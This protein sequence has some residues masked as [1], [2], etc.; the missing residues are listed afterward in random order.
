MSYFNR[1]LA[2]RKLIT[3][4]S[5]FK[6]GE[7]KVLLLSG[8]KGCGKTTLVLNFT[9]KVD[10]FY[11]SFA[12]LDD[13][14]ALRQFCKR[15]MEFLKTESI[16]SWPEA[17]S[18]LLRHRPI[19]IFDDIAAVASNKDFW[20]AFNNF[21]NNKGANRLFLYMIAEK[22][23]KLPL[24]QCPAVRL[25]MG[26][27]TISDLFKA[28]PGLSHED[29]LR[30][31]AVTGGIPELVNT[32]DA[33][34]S[35]EENLW[36]MLQPGS[37]F[38]RFCPEYLSSCFRCT[39]VYEHLLYAM[40][41]GHHRIGEIAAFTGFTSNK[42]DKYIKTM[43]ECGIVTCRQIPDKN[44]KVKTHYDLANGYFT[45]WYRYIYLN[46][47]LLLCGQPD[48][49]K[50]KMLEFIDKTLV[51]IVYREACLRF[52]LGRK[53]SHDN[54][55]PDYLFS[56]KIYPQTIS[57]GNFTY[58]FDGVFHWQERALFIKINTDPLENCGASEIERIERAMILTNK[59]L[60]DS[61]AL[62]FCRRRFSD[63]AVAAAAKEPILSLVSL[64][65]L[66]Y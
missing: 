41:K 12:G 28:Q 39:E 3:S 62:I 45:L 11:F 37:P 55:V 15:T 61:Q 16:S 40:A 17:F 38:L 60:Y 29:I 23:V 27:C 34:L 7:D 66:K 63:A 1:S 47:D 6:N 13:C 57:K 49:L 65:R 8:P 24:L 5:H 53:R 20:T 4:F 42:C 36:V 2:T 48:S 30:L 54:S 59:Q 10:R 21:W 33:R 50:P 25:E 31:Y 14:M 51:T 52:L 32:Y 64:E 58:T 56:D 46:R 43:I 26:W 18:A 19:V 9:R 44:N 22:P 35:F